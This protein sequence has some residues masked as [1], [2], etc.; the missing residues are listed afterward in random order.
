MADKIEALYQALE[1]RQAGPFEVVSRSP[2]RTVCASR[3]YGGSE[4][5]LVSMVDVLVD[6][7]DQARVSIQLLSRKDTDQGEVS[8]QRYEVPLVQPQAVSSLGPTCSFQDQQGVGRSSSSSYRLSETL[9]SLLLE[10]KYR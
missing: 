9:S 3:I 6:D 10:V 7:D 5:G 1:A 2:R 4:P 8:A